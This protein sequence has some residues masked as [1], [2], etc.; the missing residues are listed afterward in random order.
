MNSIKDTVAIVGVATTEFSEDSGRTEYSMACEVIKAAADDAGVALEDID[1]MVKDVVD[2]I[3]AMYVQK[4]L[5]METLTYSSD[6][7]WGT[8]PLINAVTALAAGICSHV[9]YYRSANNGSGKRAGSDFRAAKETK[10]ESL[11]LIRYDL[12]HPF[13]LMGPAGSAGIGIRRYLRDYGVGAEQV[14]WVPVVC[15]EHG[16][17]NPH[18][19]FRS[20]PLTIDDYLASEM[21][22]DPLRRLDIAPE[23]DGA[24]AIV[25]SRAELAA[26]LAK[27]PVYVGAVAMGTGTNGEHYSSYSRDDI[28]GLP[29]M[30]L[31]AAEL[32]RVAGVGPDDI[33]VAQLDDRFAPY[34]P[35]QLEALG[36]C[37]KG[38]GGAFCEGGDNLRVGGRIAINTGGGFLSEGFS[39]G[40]NV[41]EAVHQIRGTSTNQLDGVGL[42]MVATGAGGPADGVILHS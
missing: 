4:A 34:V 24:M 13:G 27:P 17:N 36:F 19:A 8:S 6:S 26:D 38:E 15:S 16:S 35:M 7:H 1:G 21:V 39:H 41:I 29:E 9:V 20:A 42:A 30:E 3:D 37:G 28:A 11:D 14:G 22:V 25:L 33:Q 10:D 18:A 5:G 12:H 2:G 40:V 23:V 31:M 32:Y